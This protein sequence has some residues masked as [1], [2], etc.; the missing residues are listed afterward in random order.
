MYNY[1]YKTTN[2]L[3]E[4][5]YYGVHKSKKEFDNLYYGSG[6]L[7]NR[8]IKKYGKENFTVGVIKYFD[9]YEDALEYE[10]EIIT[11]ELIELSSCYNLNIGGAGGSYKNHIK[12]LSFHKAN[13]PDNV[14]KK[15]SDTLKG[16]SYI[17]ENGRQKLRELTLTKDYKFMST[18]SSCPH[19]DQEG[20]RVAMKR[21]HFDNCK[22]RVT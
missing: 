13:V 18:T 5:F 8:A 17:T 4:K 11:D 10:K 16:K 15:I 2:T 19:C 6:V 14:R 3:N 22:K 1:V 21:W 9:T 20:Q 7:L 12:D